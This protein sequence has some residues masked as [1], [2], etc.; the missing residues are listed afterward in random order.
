MSNRLKQAWKAAGIGAIVLANVLL[1]PPLTLYL[2]NREEFT[3]PL[4]TI[5]AVYLPPALFLTAVVAALGGASSERGFSRFVSVLGAI[6]ALLWLQ[7][8]ILVWSYGVLDGSSIR[9]TEHA[10]RGVLDASVWIA[11]LL[12]AIYAHERLGKTLV[13]VAAVTFGIQL[14]A[15]AVS[16]NA[17]GDVLAGT[18]RSRA[19]EDQRALFRFSSG[20]NVVQI[21]MDGF[22]SDIFAEILRDS[23]NAALLE[24]LDGFTFFEDHMGVFPYTEMTLPAMMAGKIYRNQVPKDEFTTDAM[25]GPTILNA[26]YAAGYEIDIA[27]PVSLESVYTRG[28][29]SNSLA[30]ANNR[31][32]SERDYV[33][34]DSAKLADLALFRV[35][36]HFAKALVYRDALWILQS[37]IAGE[38]YL[39]LQYFADLAFLEQLAAN[40]TADRPVPVYKL[41]HLMLSHRP[42]VGNERCEYDGRR[43]TER[44]TVMVQAR[45]GLKHVADVLQRMRELGI[46]DRAVIV[47]M[48]D[49]GAWI[50]PEG[51][52]DAGTDDA[53][54]TPLTVGMALPVLAIKPRAARGPLAVSAAP[55]SIIDVPKTIATLTGIEAGFGGLD[56]FAI[57][58]DQV[59]VRSHLIYGYG[60]NPDRE[61]YL[62]PISEYEVDG[63]PFDADA[64]RLV[65]RHHPEGVAK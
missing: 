57:E 8:N 50:H 23:D 29:Y 9:W 49:H 42:T 11:V 17:A 27:A 43:E 34:N 39:Q 56:A 59:R 19:A 22:Q 14:L 10:W 38:G 53:A 33:L 6:A 46:Y 51:Y 41:L 63:S 26:A 64:W 48:A 3:A 54:P 52:V 65:A 40:M 58:S 37:R 5:L 4:L 24:A 60:R 2:G 61:G 32:V 15:A 31:H 20:D 7:G 28:A 13:A 1:F 55:T 16:L 47:L 36:P 45:C 21:V 25:R 62:F 12:A 35:V 44:H 30:I 18:D